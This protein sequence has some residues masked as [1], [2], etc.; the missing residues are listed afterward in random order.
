MQLYTNLGVLGARGDDVFVEW[1]PLDVGEWSRVTRHSTMFNV[2]SSSLH[3]PA[4]HHVKLCLRI[5]T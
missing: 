2:H 1:V 4:H 5:S 3:S